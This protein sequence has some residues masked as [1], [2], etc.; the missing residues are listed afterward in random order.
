M[1]MLAA[2]LPAAVGVN[3]T[4]IVQLPLTAT[5][6]PQ[7]LVSAKSLALEPVKATPLTVRAA[8]PVL[9]SVTL[10]AALV[11]PK[12]RLLKVRLLTDTLARGAEPV[13]VRVTAWGLLAALSRRVKEPVRVPDAVGAKVT[14]KV[15]LPPAATEL[16]HVPLTVKSLLLAPV[17]CV[18]VMVR[19]A[20][21]VLF[22]V[23]VWAG[24]VAP[25]DWLL[26]ARE[27]ALRLTTGPVPVPARV[28]VWGVLGALSAIVTAAERAPGE[29]GENVTA[30][31]QLAPAATL[32]PQVFDGA[33]SLALVPVT[34]MLLTVKA[35]VPVFV[36]VTG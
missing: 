35:A 26:N 34:A 24:L 23:S 17:T 18:L 7:V 32:L 3:V 15:Q 25:T 6:L 14:L 19:A 30:I 9:L 33:K 5:E 22:S 11:E 4:P 36:S 31:V 10:C 8:L 29:A 12:A 16:P 28:T 13:P 1:I 2:R 21:P 20:L 27:E